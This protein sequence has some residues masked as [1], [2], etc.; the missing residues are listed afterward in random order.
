MRK[1]LMILL[2]LTLLIVGCAGEEGERP[3]SDQT[4]P[5]EAAP[6]ETDNG[7]EA[8]PVELTLMT[9]DSFDAS[10]E[11]L[12]QFEEAHNVRLVLLPS[13]DAGTAL[14]QAILA[15]DNPLADVFFGVD[16]TF[17][18]RALEADIFETYDSPMLEQIPGR[19]QLDGTRRLLPVDFGDVCLN[20][21]KAYLEE[22]DL[23][24]PQSLDDLT[25]PAYGGLLVVENPATSSPGLAFLLATI[26]N[27]GTEGDYTYLDYWSELRQNDVLVTNDWNDAYYGNFTVASDGDRPIV[28]SYAS[29]PPA[30]VIFADPPVDEAPSAA[31][32]APGTCFR[33]V[34]FV[35]ILSGTEHRAEA[36]A[37]VDFMLS[38]TFQEDIPLRMFVFPVNENAELPEP[39]V[40]HT[41]VAEEPA[42]VDP[43]QLEANREAWIE[44]WTETVLR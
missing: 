38:E 39:F 5:P 13:G 41:E 33:Q 7:R 12:A 34:E 32:T 2:V 18:S 11:V 1:L 44:A 17:L 42:D 23:E 25:D 4:P 40:A 14:N 10:E 28:V 8:E 30:E 35:G 20:Y 21:D 22:N 29:S 26:A 36:E 31:V 16:N 6:P 24:P 19:F 9:H 27:Y 3:V 15:R 43:E 37:L